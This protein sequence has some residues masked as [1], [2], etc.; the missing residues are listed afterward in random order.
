M[1]CRFSTQSPRQ[2]GLAAETLKNQEGNHRR[3]DSQT[4][5]IHVWWDSASEFKWSR[6][7]RRWDC[8]ISKKKKN[9]VFLLALLTWGSS[10]NKEFTI[11]CHLLFFFS[12]TRMIHE[13]PTFL[14]LFQGQ[15]T[16]FCQGI[17]DVVWGYYKKCCF[18]C[19]QLELRERATDDYL[20][21]WSSSP[22]WAS[23][24][25]STSSSLPC[26]GKPMWCPCEVTSHLDRPCC[27]LISV[28]LWWAVSV[29]TLCTGDWDIFCFSFSFFLNR[30]FVLLPSSRA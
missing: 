16:C 10:C 19:L 11:C 20:V 7:Y 4:V 28:S 12:A 24:A 15:T 27:M 13:G 29:T 26:S 23:G 30:G 9:A 6:A 22:A 14:R 2:R 8:L 3:F 21:T 5:V 1:P 18:L 17:F 25:R